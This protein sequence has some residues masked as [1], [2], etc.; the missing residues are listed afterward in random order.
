[1]KYVL[2]GSVGNIS[3]PIA[4][5]LIKAGHDVSVISSSENKKKTIE[6]LGAK[7]LIGSIDDISF[8]ADSFKAADAVYLMIPPKWDV[9][10]WLEYQKMVANNYTKA[11]RLSSVKNLVVLSSVGAHMGTGAG[12]VDGLAYLESVI[13]ELKDIN[14]VYLRPSYFYY[15]LFSMVPLIKN[16]KI[17][18]SN[19]PADH[20][21]W[22]THTDDIAA[23]A[24]EKLLQLNF[25]GKEYINIASD[26]RTWTEI[27]AALTRSVGLQ[28]IPW[29]EFTDKQS[30][31]G[32]LQAG[33]PQ[34]IANGYVAMGAALRSGEMEADININPPTRLGKIKLEDFTNEFAAKYN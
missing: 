3:K 11:V 24:S 1:M 17:M 14:A 15:N 27:T 7:P 20:K 2:T 34:T 16:A 21:L 26:Q 12:P 10:N 13:N 5:T 18:G 6:A 28:N 4:Q 25:K 23:I 29:V 19:Q 31:D 32:M 8:L 30:L 9:T 22:L 33:L